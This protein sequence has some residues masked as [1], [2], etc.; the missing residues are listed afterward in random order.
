MFG[1]VGEKKA[2]REQLISG[3]YTASLSLPPSLLL[4][5]FYT[6]RKRCVAVVKLEL[7]CGEYKQAYSTR[8]V[9]LDRFAMKESS[10][11]SFS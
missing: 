3:G 8:C 1:L 6:T 11:E 4:S 5:T 7:E 9:K 10:P 2:R